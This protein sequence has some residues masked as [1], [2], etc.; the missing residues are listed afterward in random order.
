[1]FDIR[2]MVF[3][4]FGLKVKRNKIIQRDEEDEKMFTKYKLVIAAIGV[5]LLGACG[6]GGGAEGSE[7]RPS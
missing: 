4:K 6:S 3:R 7:G 5:V 2:G 1:M